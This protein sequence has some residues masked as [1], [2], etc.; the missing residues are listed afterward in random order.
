MKRILLLLV[1]CLTLIGL[2]G[3][4]LKV[5]GTWEMEELTT[6]ILGF[7]KT[8]QVGEEYL[9]TELTSDYIVVEF[10]LDGTGTLT[11]KGSEP[12]NI[13]WEINEDTVKIV[14]SN[15]AEITAKLDDKFL[16][17]DM[18]GFGTGVVFKLVRKG[19]F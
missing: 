9:G 16:V 2:S 18:T 19:L 15:D 17:I 1:C 4:S 14:D 10:K 11:M 5:M 8:L 13:T 7:E 3:C 12:Q 6:K